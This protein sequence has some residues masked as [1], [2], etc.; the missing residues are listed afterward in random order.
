MKNRVIIHVGMPKTGS[1]WLQS[2]IFPQVTSHNIIYKQYFR[3]L[4]YELD[5]AKDTL[6][7]YENYA[8][9]PHKVDTH[10][11][12]GWCETRKK[13]LQ[14]LANLFPQAEIILVIRDHIDLLN[15]LYNQ[16]IKVG[17][18]IDFKEFALGTSFYSLEK[19]ALLYE[20]LIKEIKTQFPSRLLIIDYKLF[21]TD[22]KR[23]GQSFFNFI[24]SN[25]RIDFDTFAGLM[26]N[27]SLPPRQIRSQLVM[28]KIFSNKYS[29]GGIKISK[30]FFKIIR[31]LSGTTLSY[32]FSNKPFCDSEITRELSDYFFEDREYVRRLL[33]NG[34]AII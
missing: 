6:I 28:N 12:N 14:N 9:F 21:K 13:A 34:F 23:F 32:F 30:N 4:M 31:S 8:G 25:D 22:K 11:L 15:S 10:T 19:N 5:P 33:H 24:G 26:V 7:S 16:Y 18:C 1:T 3:D 17:G 2:H 27:S 20:S 29:P